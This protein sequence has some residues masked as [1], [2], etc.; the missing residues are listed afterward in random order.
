MERRH[1]EHC[2]AHRRVRRDDT[3][4]AQLLI[5]RGLRDQALQRLARH[6]VAHRLRR[7]LPLRQVARRLRHAALVGL[8]ELRALDGLAADLGDPGGGAD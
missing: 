4:P 1:R 5:Q 6:R 2:L 3:Q 8:L 7:L